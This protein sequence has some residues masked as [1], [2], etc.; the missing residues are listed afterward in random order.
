MNAVRFLTD[1]LQ[2]D[3]YF[4]TDHAGQNLERTRRQRELAESLLDHLGEARAIVA[5]V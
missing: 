2:G 4:R 5:G 1:H 3:A